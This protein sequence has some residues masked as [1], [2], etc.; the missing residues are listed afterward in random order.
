MIKTL[1]YAFVAALM[2]VAGAVNAQTT[3]NFK[4]LWEAKAVELNKTS[5]YLMNKECGNGEVTDGDITLK[6]EAGD[7]SSQPVYAAYNAETEANTKVDPTACIKLYGAKKN[8]GKMEGSSMTLSKTG[9]KMTKIIF[10]APT[11]RFGAGVLKASTGTVAMD[12]KT[13]D[14]TWVGEADNVKFTVCKTKDDITV[15]LHFVEITVN[16]SGTTGINNITVD[17]AKKGVRY[18]LA[19]QRVNESYKGVVIENGKK[20]IVK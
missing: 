15:L 9:G 19:G 18:N 16:P 20:I 2:M 7:C 10:K 3:F 1:R 4:N 14:W 5:L 8:T 6:F 11:K 17:N 13:R 12:K